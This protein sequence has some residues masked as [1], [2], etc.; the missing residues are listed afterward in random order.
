M[1]MVCEHSV[2]IC[3]FPKKSGDNSNKL[4]FILLGGFVF[5]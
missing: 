3:N 2:G 1:E 5:A 4:I